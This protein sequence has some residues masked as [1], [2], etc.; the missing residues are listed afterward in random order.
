MFTCRG[1]QQAIGKQLPVYERAK[2]IDNKAQVKNH[3][4]SDTGFPSKLTNKNKPNRGA[5]YFLF[6]HPGAYLQN[7]AIGD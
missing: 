7:V 1:L 4:S 3:G 6:T 2:Q 5:T